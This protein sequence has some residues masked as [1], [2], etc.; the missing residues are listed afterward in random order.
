MQR[1]TSACFSRTHS[2]FLDNA[3]EWKAPQ[4][5]LDFMEKAR[6]DDK[7]LCYIGFGS[8]VVDDPAGVTRNIIEA[9]KDADV[10]AIVSKGWSGRMSKKDDKGEQKEVKDDEPIPDEVY[11]VD[12]IPH[13]W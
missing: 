4:S 6:K 9:V 12:S 13:D 8:I 7:K 1:M 5:L 2:W 11:V 3:E 10:R